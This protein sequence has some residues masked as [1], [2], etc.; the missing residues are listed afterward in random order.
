[1]HLQPYQ[2]DE[3]KFAYCLHVYFRWHTYWRRSQPGLA[4]ITPALIE[5]ERPDIRILK[6]KANET[7]LALLASLRPSHS[8]SIAA[9]KIKGAVSKIA[10]Q[11]AHD[12]GKH[13]TVGDGYFACTV[14]PRT[15]AELDRYLESQASHH[16]YDR[17][18]NA[19][20]FVRTWKDDPEEG[21]LQAHHAATQVQ[22]HFVFCTWNRKGTFTR[23]ASEQVVRHWESCIANPQ[24]R[25]IKVS[26]LPDHVHL[27][28]RVHPEIVPGKLVP[29][30]LNS[31]QEL[32]VAEFPNMLIRTGN[33]RM[34]KPGAYLG[35]VG[36]LS[37]RQLLAY[38]DQWH[39]RSGPA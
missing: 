11:I 32:M 9:S 13:K 3:L 28:L 17:Q 12:D 22:W 1:M 30:F 5:A 26:F 31:A 4:Q 24:I 29:E 38:L 6:L 15:S 10:R 27:A 2:L 34:W 36:N 14:G 21:S 35:T 7:D 37:N 23:D 20:V 18:V 19:P 8:V 16:G 25:F 39:R 33:R